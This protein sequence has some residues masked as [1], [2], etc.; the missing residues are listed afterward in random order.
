MSAQ[1][2]RS[3]FPRVV[4][5]IEKSE[6]VYVVKTA[7]KM[8]SGWRQEVRPFSS[9]LTAWGYYRKIVKNNTQAF[10]TAPK[11]STNIPHAPQAESQTA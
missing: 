4:L 2:H 1:F 9:Q 8:R 7:T 6:D 10:K 5:V 3:E 11:V